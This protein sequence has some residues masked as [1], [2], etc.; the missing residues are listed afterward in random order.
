MSPCNFH[1]DSSDILAGLEWTLCGPLL[2]KL[3]KMRQ[4]RDCL[5]GNRCHHNHHKRGGEVCRGNGNGEGLARERFVQIKSIFPPHFY[6][7]C[8][9]GFFHPEKGPKKL[10]YRL[11]AE[12]KIQIVKV[13]DYLSHTGGGGS[14]TNPLRLPTDEDRGDLRCKK[15]GEPLKSEEGLGHPPPPPKVEIQ[16]LIHGNL[17]PDLGREGSANTTMECSHTQS[18]FWLNPCLPNSEVGWPCIRIATSIRGGGVGGGL[19]ATR[20]QGSNTAAVIALSDTHLHTN[21]EGGLWQR[22]TGG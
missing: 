19:I 10:G 17:A 7:A 18:S 13:N 12:M 6:R 15:R 1:S 11:R 9:G 14:S 22:D 5:W 8:W 4:R 2:R 21:Q 16:I 20:D 3:L